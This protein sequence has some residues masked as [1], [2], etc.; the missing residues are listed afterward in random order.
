MVS[1][2]NGTWT[3]GWGFSSACDLKCSFC[4]SRDVRRE[5]E[6]TAKGLNE[7]EEFLSTNSSSIGAL[8]FGTGE[9]FMDPA[10]LPLLDKCRELVP[11]ARI[12]VTTNGMF[13]D[14]A[15]VSGQN[16]CLQRCIDELDVSVDFAAEVLHDKSRGKQ[17]AWNRAMRALEQAINMGIETTIVMV[18]T[19]DTLTPDNVSGMFRLA[20]S[21]GVGLRLNVYMPTSRDFTHSPS[22]DQLRESITYL[23]ERALQLRSSDPLLGALLGSYAPGLRIAAG[24]SCRILPD[25]RVSPSTYLVESPWISSDRVPV[26]RLENLHRSEP[27]MAFHKGCIPET[28]SACCFADTCLGGSRERRWLWF[29]NF[30]MRDPYCPFV[31]DDSTAGIPWVVGR[32]HKTDWQGATVHLDYLPTVIAHPAKTPSMDVIMCAKALLKSAGSILVLKKPHHSEGALSVWD[33]PGGRLMEGERHEDALRREL[34]EEIGAGVCGSI[35]PRYVVFRGNL[36]SRVLTG[37]TY[38]VSATCR[39]ICLSHEHSD[40]IWVTASE[41]SLFLIENGWPKDVANAYGQLA[42]M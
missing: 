37:R 20:Q 40:S 33:L 9:C 7:A 18:G 6:C 17:G 30:N 41:L 11:D 38:R 36:G 34:S 4:Y 31:V 10:F 22:K 21:F 39:D 3:V 32:E 5:T 29:D 8:N 16:A 15:A 19:K 35:D 12:A 42:C 26:A 28:C 27:F 14:S 1:E 25:G 24:N 23:A 13:A 2:A